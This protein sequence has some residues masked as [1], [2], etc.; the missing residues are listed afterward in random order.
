MP[1]LNVYLRNCVESTNLY[2]RKINYCYGGF[3]GTNINLVSCQDCKIQVS[4]HSVYVE[5][6]LAPQCTKILLILKEYLTR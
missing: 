6:T 5:A 2:S 3:S 4:L 1:S